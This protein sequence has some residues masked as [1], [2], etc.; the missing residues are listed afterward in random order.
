MDNITLAPVLLKKMTKEEAE[1][2]GRELLTRVG[3]SE[4]ADVRA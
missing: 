4:K 1:Q 2:R 3:L